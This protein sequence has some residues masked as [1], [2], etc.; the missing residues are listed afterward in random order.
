MRF[1]STLASA[2]ALVAGVVTAQK[3]SEQRFLDF[4]ARLQ[5]AAAPVVLDDDSYKALTS[6]P[7]DYSVAVLLTALGN[8]FGCQLCRDFQPE[9]D[10]IGRS[11]AKGDKAGKSRMLLG[12]LDFADGRD[13]FLAVPFTLYS[14]FPCETPV[15]NS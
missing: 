13:S 5:A 14:P 1:L 3:S 9:W 6:P 2:C 11:W 12:T 4:H 10:L 7:R 8:R 15:A